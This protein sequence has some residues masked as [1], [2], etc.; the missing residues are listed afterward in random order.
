MTITQPNLEDPDDETS[1]LV[2]PLLA[3]LQESVEQLAL[4]VDELRSRTP[5]AP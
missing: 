4:A 5:R 3:A 2:Y 1:D